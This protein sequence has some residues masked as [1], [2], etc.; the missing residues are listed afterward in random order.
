[1][2]T[3]ADGFYKT[4]TV[5]APLFGKHVGRFFCRRRTKKTVDDQLTFDDALN[6]LLEEARQ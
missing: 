5:K 2:T 3:P 4:Y 1:M 6:D